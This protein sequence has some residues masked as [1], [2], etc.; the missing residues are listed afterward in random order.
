MTHSPAFPPTS[1]NTTQGGTTPGATLSQ[2]RGPYDYGTH[3]ETWVRDEIAK[4]EKD[5]PMKRNMNEP[6]FIDLRNGGNLDRV[7]DDPH[8]SFERPIFDPIVGKVW[9][10]VVGGTIVFWVGVFAAVVAA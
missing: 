10:W 3:G 5:T 7:Y 2:R 8:V 9:R 1:Q 6:R 4:A